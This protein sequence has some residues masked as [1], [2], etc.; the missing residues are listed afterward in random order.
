MQVFSTNLGTI[1]IWSWIILGGGGGWGPHS[2]DASSIFSSIVTI[3]NI[4]RDFQ[5]SSESAKLSPSI[6]NQWVL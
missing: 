3:N 5:L 1:H 2:Q 4:S 6:E